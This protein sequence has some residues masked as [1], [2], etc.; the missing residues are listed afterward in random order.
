LWRDPDR[1]PESNYSER[2][3]TGLPVPYL[4]MFKRSLVFLGKLLLFVAVVW[5]AVMAYWK[6]TDHVVSSEDLLIYF[7]I[8]PVALLLAYLLFRIVWWVSL[9]AFRL[10][11]TPA[12]VQAATPAT[13][14][15]GN[16]DGSRPVEAHPAAYV[17]ATA[18]STHFG[19]EAEQFLSAT[20]QEKRRAGLNEDITRELGYGVR[21]AD[22]DRLEFDTAH[23]SARITLLRTRALLENVHVQLESVLSRAA[24][25][26]ESVAGADRHPR[27]V[28]LHPEW[29]GESG[30]QDAAPATNAPEALRGPL[31][32]GLSVHIVLPVFLTAAEA[33]LIQTA[34]LE[35]LDAAGWSRQLMKAMTIQPDNDVDYLRRLE[36]WMQQPASEA[37]AG[38]WLLVLS[39]VSWLDMDL[40]NDRLRKDL[41]FADRLARGGAAIG[42][43]ACG[44]VLAKARPDSRLQLEPLA[45]LSRL[46]LAQRNKPVDAKGTIEA[47]LLTAM[48]ADQLS[49][50]REQDKQFVGLAASGDMNDGRA[51]EL[52]RWVTDALPQ[53]DFI[54]DV[55]CAA[56]HV[57]ECEPAGSLLALA[58]AAAM[59]QQRSGS[60]LYCSN[61][62]A[63]W[64]ALAAVM[65]AA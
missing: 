12:T 31:P 17:L 52:G 45:Q 32:A 36:A 29:H 37:S 25:S 26:A 56:E 13:A 57:G 41:R 28:Q 55:M 63:S 2:L 58:L 53:L 39:A 33:S 15:A 43:L 4:S 27:G 48:L 50:L 61:Q 11:K 22:V 20:M 34:V 35:W 8:L 19:E 46:T 38:E 7:L 3:S 9:K 47:E 5:L 49:A 14:Q 18:M 16:S 1:Q 60:V 44:L 10:L 40:L 65:P 21:A 62:H 24:P 59:A 23:D 6:Y 51:V 54:E 30:Q 64:R 42:E